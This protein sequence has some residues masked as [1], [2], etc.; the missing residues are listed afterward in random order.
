M[1][2]IKMERKRRR[3][4]SRMAAAAEV[5]RVRRD[6]TLLFGGTRRSRIAAGTAPRNADASTPL[7]SQELVVAEVWH[8]VVAGRPFGRSQD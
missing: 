3:L 4:A 1:V 2:V 6:S 7:H 5:P 8:R